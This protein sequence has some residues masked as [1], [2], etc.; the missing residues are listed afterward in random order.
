MKHVNLIIKSENV[1]FR[2]LTFKK[3]IYEINIRYK[4]K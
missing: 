2:I 4:I 3:Y 1:S